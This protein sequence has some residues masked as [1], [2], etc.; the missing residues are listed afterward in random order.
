MNFF[1]FINNKFNFL[2]QI[3][4]QTILLRMV[5]QERYGIIYRK[6]F[7]NH[8]FLLRV[9]KLFVT[10]YLCILQPE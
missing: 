5:L 3:S 6:P 2:T 1:T 8:Y 7:L 9:I 4:L 10:A